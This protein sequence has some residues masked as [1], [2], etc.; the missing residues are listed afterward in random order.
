LLLLPLKT[1]DRLVLECLLKEWKLML[2]LLLLLLV[3][4]VS[5]VS[6]MFLISSAFLALRARVFFNKIA[7]KLEKLFHAPKKEEKNKTKQVGR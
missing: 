3:V 6:T 4:E 5:K 2:L 1:P 7:N